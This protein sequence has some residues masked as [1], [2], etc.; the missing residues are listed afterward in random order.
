MLFCI[1][2]WI[3]QFC[4][5][6]R[7]NISVRFNQLDINVWVISVECLLLIKKLIKTNCDNVSIYSKYIKKIPW[8]EMPQFWLA[9]L[10]KPNII[11]M[12]RW[13]A[14]YDYEQRFW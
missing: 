9:S 11:V 10:I 12:T 13:V 7:V 8:A 6:I 1:F 4:L 5:I 3:V 14:Y 2:S